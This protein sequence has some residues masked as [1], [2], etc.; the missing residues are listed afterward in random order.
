[1]YPDYLDWRSRQAS[2]D[3]LA[4]SIVVGGVLTGG[5]DAER[6]FGRA[7]TRSFFPTL[8]A[9]FQIGGGFTA[10]EDRPG[11]ARA[12]VLS[13]R[14]WQ[15]RYGGDHALVGRTVNYNDE[16][17][18]VVGVLTADFDLY[19]RANANN[20]FFVALGPLTLADYMRDRDSHPVRVIG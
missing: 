1:A 15:R 20:D 5:G 2:F 12:V 4:A 19:G 14:L 13:H 3:D 7:V 6:V 10:D 16:V 9:P 11:A 17:Y 8:G 18:T